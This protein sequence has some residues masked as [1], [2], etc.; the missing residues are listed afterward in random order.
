M[1]S[2]SPKSSLSSLLLLLQS[3]TQLLI[4]SYRQGAPPNLIY[5]LQFLENHQSKISCQN[6]QIPLH[7]SEVGKWRHPEHM[8]PYRYKT[9]LIDRAQSQK[10]SQL[11]IDHQPKCERILVLELISHTRCPCLLQAHYTQSA[12]INFQLKKAY[13]STK[14]TYGFWLAISLCVYFFKYKFLINLKLNNLFLIMTQTIGLE[15]L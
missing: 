1:S 6:Q 15:H 2:I 9:W 5:C 10:P 13:P 3:T 12:L 11:A 7:S 14:K 4:Q 8:P